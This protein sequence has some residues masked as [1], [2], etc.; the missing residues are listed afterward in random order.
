MDDLSFLNNINS[1][2][3]ESL[4]QNYLKDKNSVDSSWRSFFQGFELG[5]KNYKAK[6]ESSNQTLIGKEFNVF[7]LIQA[8]RQRGHYFTLT[9]P[10]RK[11]RQYKPD[12]SIENFE[13]GRAHV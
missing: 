4:Y 2:Q 7:D 5:F 6:P 1:E 9:N 10:V 11:R 13:I 3:I 8:Y 12:L